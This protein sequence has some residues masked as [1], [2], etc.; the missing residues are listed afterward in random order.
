L[1]GQV[2]GFGPLRQAHVRYIVQMVQLGVEATGQRLRTVDR[3]NNFHVVP[4][5]AS[6]GQLVWREG[7]LIED[8][9]YPHQQPLPTSCVDR[10]TPGHRRPLA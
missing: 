3:E 9:H 2:A 7:L 8:L 10:V 5:V 1:T 4:M 6:P